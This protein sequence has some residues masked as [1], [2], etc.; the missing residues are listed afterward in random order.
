MN[1]TFTYP[2]VSYADIIDLLHSILFWKYE[3]KVEQ[4]IA[5]H[6][7]FV[8]FDTVWALLVMCNVLPEARIAK[9]RGHRELCKLLLKKT[10][11]TE[12]YDTRD[13]KTVFLQG[14]LMPFCVRKNNRELT[15]GNTVNL[16]EL[17]TRRSIYI[18]RLGIR[19]AP[20]AIERI[21]RLLNKK[22]YL[23]AWERY[24]APFVDNKPALIQRVR[25]H[26]AALDTE[27]WGDKK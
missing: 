13:I 11:V 4:R 12:A 6:F 7:W 21:A 15:S 18:T 5:T 1:S 9:L 25:S 24:I 23:E 20:F 10:L 17:C 26:H 3:E 16:L 22:Q 8:R 2:I 27:I 14:G 19:Q